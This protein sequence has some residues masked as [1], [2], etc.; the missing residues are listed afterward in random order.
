M[1]VFDQVAQTYDKIYET[2][3][4]AEEDAHIRRTLAAT[5]RSCDRVIDLGC[6]TGKGLELLPSVKA[7][8][9]ID[10]SAE[11]ITVARVKGV[12][13]PNAEFI[14]A[15]VLILPFADREF[16]GAVS[17]FA[18]SYFTPPMRAVSET[19]RVLRTGSPLV[20]VAYAPRWWF[21]GV[22]AIMKAN[23]EV[24]ICPY[25]ESLFRERFTGYFDIK[26]IRPLSVIPKGLAA[27]FPDLLRIE[28]LLYNLI[29]PDFGR[30]IVLYG[31]RK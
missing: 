29:S 14:E 20:V 27:K 5:H 7:Y 3:L 2:E 19:A 9:G 6:G 13:Y 11:M 22:D 23:R 17:L 16:D 10:T 1:S 15:D 24:L 28:P 30:Y 21:G 12:K 4:C 18:F 8:T 26:S 31:I 25:T